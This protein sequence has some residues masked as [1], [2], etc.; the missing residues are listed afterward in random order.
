MFAGGLDSAGKPYIARA[1]FSNVMRVR[2]PSPVHKLWR[3]AD[4]HPQI[5]QITL[6]APHLENGK[7]LGVAAGFGFPYDMDAHGAPL[8]VRFPFLPALP[9]DVAGIRADVPGTHRSRWS[10]ATRAAQPSA[11]A[12]S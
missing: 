11:R 10:R 1:H 2:T 5:A 4:A 8:H 7:G 3:T 12:C 9:F 6:Y